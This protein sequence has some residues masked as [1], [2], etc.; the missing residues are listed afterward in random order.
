MSLLLQDQTNEPN[1]SPSAAHNRIRTTATGTSSDS[2]YLVK[3]DQ[4]K[5]QLHDANLTNQNND[6]VSSP[7]TQPKS[8]NRF[9]SSISKLV[10]TFPA[11]NGKKGMKHT[12]SLS[13]G[14]AVKEDC[15]VAP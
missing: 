2:V 11:L 13:R 15:E 8:S 6:K 12:S 3:A 4:E 7:V 10:E 5:Q 14:S 9:Q 1:S